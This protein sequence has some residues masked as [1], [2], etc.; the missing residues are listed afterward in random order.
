MKIYQHIPTGSYITPKVVRASGMNTYTEC[1][2]NGK[3]II[4]KR[5]WTC[6][7]SDQVFIINGFENLKEI[8]N[9]N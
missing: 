3:P 9:Q 5:S 7:E 2:V 1:D 8:D 4:K 6:R